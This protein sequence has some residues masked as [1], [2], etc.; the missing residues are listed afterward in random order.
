[1]KVFF[2]LGASCLVV[3]TVAAQ[4]QLPAGE[5][6]VLIERSCNTQCHGAEMVLR[7]KK[8]PKQW[9]AVVEEMAA[10]GA[11]VTPAERKVIAEYL[12]KHY[13]LTVNINTASARQIA[14]TLEL[15]I[16]LGIAIVNHRKKAGPFE[17]WEDLAKVPGVQAKDIEDKKDRLVF[18]EGQ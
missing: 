7:S 13:P 18:E 14:D 5:G 10:L 1:M 16:K 11:K 3:F 4:V 8:T 15:P 2:V 17:T 12:A 6:K 9:A